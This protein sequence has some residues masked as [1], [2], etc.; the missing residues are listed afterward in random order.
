MKENKIYVVK[1]YIIDKPL[2]PDT[3][4]MLYSCF[5]ECQKKLYSWI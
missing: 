4:S 1:E 3:D 2:T 5:K